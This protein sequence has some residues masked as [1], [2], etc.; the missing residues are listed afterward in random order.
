MEQR[1]VQ[2]TYCKHSPSPKQLI[3]YPYYMKQFARKWYLVAVSIDAPD[4]LQLFEI[5]RIKSYNFHPNTEY[6]PIDIDMNNYFSDIYGIHREFGKN[7]VTIRF[8]VSR[9]HID[10]LIDDPIHH[11]Q[12]LISH[13][14]DGAIFSIRVI[15]NKEL[16]QKFLSYGDTVTILTDCELRDEIVR[17]LKKAMRNY[18]SST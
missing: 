2:I 3:I 5:A 7:P 4:T 11:S 18:E 14:H 15:P 10:L 1:T 8:Q 6:K 9:N 16:T 12:V 17:K 13:S